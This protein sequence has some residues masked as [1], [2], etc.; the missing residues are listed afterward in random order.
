[1]SVILRQLES[2]RQPFNV[3][4]YKEVGRQFFDDLALVVEPLGFNVILYDDGLSDTHLW[5]IE[6]KAE[7]D[8]YYRGYNDGLEYQLQSA[9]KDLD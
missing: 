9:Q 5:L 6:P 2:D 1:M 3:S 7:S 4:D 8:D